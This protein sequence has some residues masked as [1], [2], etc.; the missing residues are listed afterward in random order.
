MST[1]LTLE[2]F[3]ALTNPAMETP[4]GPLFELYRRAAAQRIISAGDFLGI[5]DLL[6]LSGYHTDENLALHA[7]LLCMFKTLSDGSLCLSLQE[8]SLSQM[9]ADIA[10]AESGKIAAAIVA[11][12]NQWPRLIGG[13][14]EFKP[15]LRTTTDTEDLLYFQRYFLYERK[16]KQQLSL[17]L[18][19]ETEAARTARF[20][21]KDLGAII[22]EVLVKRPVLTLENAPLI[23]TPKQKQALC[24]PLFNDFVIVSGGPGS[25]KT[26]VVVNILRCLSRLNFSTDRI[27]L[28]APTGRAAFRLTESIRSALASIKNPSAADLALSALEA[29]TIHRLLKYRPSRHDFTYSAQNQIP[30]DVLII[31]EASMVDVCMMAQLL[32]SLPAKSKVIL[33]G[34][35]DQLPSVDAGAVLADLIPGDD[36]V[37]FS[38]ELSAKL[39]LLLGTPIMSSKSQVPLRDRIVVLD[40]SHRMNAG[41]RAVV[42]ELKKGNS[43]AALDA[44]CAISIG[45]PVPMAAASK[46]DMTDF[47]AAIAW[48]PPGIGT[49]AKAGGYAWIDLGAGGAERWPLI[50]SAWAEH[51]YL[52]KNALRPDS[53]V[54]LIHGARKLPLFKDAAILDHAASKDVLKLLFDCIRQAQILSLV[55]NGRYGCTGINRRLCQILKPHFDEW[56]RDEAFSGMPILITRN[57]YG[58][59]LFNGDVGVILKSGGALRAVFQRI[60]LDDQNRAEPG[61]VAVALDAL[62]PWEPAFAVTVHKSQGSEYEQVLLVVPPENDFASAKLA[63]PESDLPPHRLQTR[64]IIYTGLTRAKHLAILCG[65]RPDIQNAIAREIKRQSGLSLW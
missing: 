37:L 9:L 56:A 29:R 18:A 54:N 30:A 57:D 24:L 21:E 38:P 10:G 8:D 25:G 51:Q 64:E 35:R 12:L 3:E 52:E 13:A 45:K 23:W 32:E 20:D 22:D 41:L 63:G 27:R 46:K 39:E 33:L 48:P 6:E 26:T 17:R 59:N 1:L 60:V 15:L 11:Q 62:P 53:Y 19:P 31:D 65:T 14:N 7:L 34:D 28:A 43:Q 42:G 58:L 5:R 36:K 16:L 47:K 2:F 55:R 4:E 49:A 40:V 61:F 50:L 44:A